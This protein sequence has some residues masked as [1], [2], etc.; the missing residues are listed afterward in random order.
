VVEMGT[1]RIDPMTPPAL[2]LRFL[3]RRNLWRIALFGGILG[4]AGFFVLGGYVTLGMA[5]YAADRPGES[6]RGLRLV[7]VAIVGGLHLGPRLALRLWYLS[8]PLGMLV[9]CSWS[10]LHRLGRAWRLRLAAETKPPPE[11]A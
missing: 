6:P 11:I 9:A 1:S 8:V 4:L 10:A 5:S 2:D 7:L 3:I